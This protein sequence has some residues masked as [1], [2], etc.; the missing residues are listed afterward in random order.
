MPNAVE[1]RLRQAGVC[2][3]GDVEAREELLREETG[4]QQARQ[5][6]NVPAALLEI[7]GDG[8]EFDQNVH[9]VRLPEDSRRDS[10]GAFDD[11][12]ENGLVQTCV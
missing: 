6:R 12:I 2:G 1:V 5:R 11:G 4:R 10:A 3:E 7:L 8:A 9:A